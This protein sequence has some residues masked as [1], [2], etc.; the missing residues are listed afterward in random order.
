MNEEIRMILK[1]IEEG[2]ITADQAAELIEAI[3]DKDAAYDEEGVPNEDQ[4]RNEVESMEGK[5]SAEHEG[6]IAKD[7]GPAKPSRAGLDDMVEELKAFG[8][9]IRK[10]LEDSQLKDTIRDAVKKALSNA[11]SSLTNLAG[12]FFDIGW[13]GGMI[14]RSLEGHLEPEEADSVIHLFLTGRN[15]SIKLIGWDQP[16]YK[17]VAV[18]RVPSGKEAEY[19]F[20]DLVQYRVG[21]KNLE[22]EARGD[23]FNLKAVSLQAFVPKRF[24]YDVALESSNGSIEVADISCTKIHAE[25]S[26]GKI[27][28]NRV[29]TDAAYV[30]TSNG[31][32]VLNTSSKSLHCETTNGS[33]SVTPFGIDGTST[34]ELETSN[35]AVK[36][37]VPEDMNLGVSIAAEVSC[38]GIS[39]DVP[40][41]VYEL[42]E[43][44]RTNQE[45]RAKSMNFEDREK[46]LILR[47]E[48]SNGGISVRKE[49]A[50]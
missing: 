43:R 19:Q 30:E 25:T 9:N 11:G 48:T 50:A 28:F 4:T 8:S 32:V 40:D 38:G 10:E 29:R 22:F 35:G 13:G 7:R 6:K 15:G 17:V 16:G 31:A 39:V 12:N 1:M 24:T 3:R 49:T 34:W 36:A 47:I 21:E 14:Q 46:K 45:I 2:K 44:G 20:E 26:N 18:A 33:I 42:N 27:D 37:V 41:L 23:R 5:R